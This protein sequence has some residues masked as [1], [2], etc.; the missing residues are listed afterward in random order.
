M[1]LPGEPP[2]QRTYWEEEGPWHL[3]RQGP[4]GQRACVVR[5]CEAGQEPG[6]GGGSGGP[7]ATKSTEAGMGAGP[8]PHSLLNS[9]PAVSQE[10]QPSALKAAF[11]LM[12][13]L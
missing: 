12:S 4:E 5:I 1:A 8:A 6:L 13:N 11:G 2:S 3:P 10:G 7:E 9:A